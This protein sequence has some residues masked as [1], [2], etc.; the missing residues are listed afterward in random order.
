MGGVVVHAQTQQCLAPLPLTPWRLVLPPRPENDLTREAAFD[1]FKTALLEQVAQS[2]ALFTDVA[3]KGVAQ[4]SIDHYFR[5]YLLYH[6]VFRREREVDAADVVY[7]LE[8][9]AAVP[10]LA[11]FVSEEALEAQR[12]KEAAQQA[13]REASAAEAEAME[14]KLTAALE[15]KL[16]ELAGDGSVGRLN[17]REVQAML[18]DS[19]AG[20]LEAYREQAGVALRESEAVLV[21]RIARLEASLKH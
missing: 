8:T 2:P 17:P 6:Y 14:A 5:H 10:P 19:V 9:A 12:A 1:L 7:F 18:L 20:D 15:A 13:R 11:D 21:A 3:L 16:P 4:F